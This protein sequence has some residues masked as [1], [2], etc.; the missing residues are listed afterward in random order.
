MASSALQQLPSRLAPLSEVLARIDALAGAVAPNAVDVSAAAGRVLA[1]DVMVEG[2]LP[3]AAISLRDG[4]AVRADAVADAGPYAPVPLI[5]PPAFVEVGAAL[6]ADADAVLPPDA[7]TIRSGVAEATAAAVPGDGVLLAGAEVAAGQIL[8]RA[9][10]R[11][12]SVDVAV[13]RAAGVPRV[14]VRA[15]RVVFITAGDS[16]P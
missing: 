12:R 13:L 3:P 9:G 14:T 1:A 16:T 4:W 2:P 7:A 15:P 10:E 5:P 6:P 11:L 8:R